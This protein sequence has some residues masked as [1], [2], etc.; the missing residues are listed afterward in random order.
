MMHMY[1]G[2]TWTKA[3]REPT[4]PRLDAVDKA[5]YLLQHVAHDRHGLRQVSDDLNKIDPSRK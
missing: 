1:Y 3:F 4:N 5:K 2:M